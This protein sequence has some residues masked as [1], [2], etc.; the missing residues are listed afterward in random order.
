MDAVKFLA[1]RQID[2][3]SIFTE[4]TEIAIEENFKSSLLSLGY[5]LEKQVRTWWD[6][7]TMEQYVKDN[8][9]VRSLR[10]EVTPQDGLDDID[11]MTEWLD[12]F[13]G[14]GFKLQQLVLRR[15]QRK[16]AKLEG[17]IKELLTK[18]DPIKDTQQWTDFNNNISKKLEK[19]DR[20]TQ[21]KKVKK[22]HRDMGDFRNHTMYGKVKMPPIRLRP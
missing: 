17:L 4:D 7:S 21:K 20:D 12:F 8:I 3:N 13:N 6:I 2:L 10:W 19:I 16:M 5:A 1:N 9:I 22:Y 18:L 14:V 11:S 15:K